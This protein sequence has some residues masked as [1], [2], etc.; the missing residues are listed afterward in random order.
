MR[1]GRQAVPSSCRTVELRRR[2]SPSIPVVEPP[3][4]DRQDRGLQPVQT[5]VAPGDIVEVPPPGGPSVVGE[6]SN[7]GAQGRVVG[8]DRSRI[9]ERAE[10]LPGVEAEGGSS[11]EG[12]RPTPRPRGTVGLCGILDDRDPRSVGDLRDRLHVGHLP[13]EMYDN[14]RR[15]PCRDRRF[16]V[17]FRDEQGVGVDVRED[18][19]G[20][21]RHDCLEGRHEGVGGH[22][23]FVS[24]P[25][26]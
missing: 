20:A 15:G 6:G 10:V 16:H 21:D 12:A 25:D 22:D 24:Q 14:H 13:V 7:P 5:A 3:K 2:L 19:R 18:G 1:S 26:L 17:G 8:D 23:D 11:T 9:A 4:L